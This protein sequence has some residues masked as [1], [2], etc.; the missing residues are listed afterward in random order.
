M[1]DLIADC[2]EKITFVK[3]PSMEDYMETNKATRTL[4]KTLI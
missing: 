4:A 3:N 2:M 1:S